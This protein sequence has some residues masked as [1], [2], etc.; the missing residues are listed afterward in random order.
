MNDKTK[1]KIELSLVGASFSL[2]NLYLTLKG[3]PIAGI[4]F[5]VVSAVFYIQA[6]RIK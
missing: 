1:R 2:L 3:F 6:L 4:G 5:G